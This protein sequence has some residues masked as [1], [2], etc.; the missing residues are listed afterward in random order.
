MALVTQALVLFFN[1]FDE[2]WKV[3]YK[4]METRLSH[5][6]CLVLTYETKQA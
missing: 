5:D 3:D 4:S 2:E 1:H 6:V